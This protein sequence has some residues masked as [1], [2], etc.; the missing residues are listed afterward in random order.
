MDA[1]L[2]GAAI[3]IFL[4]LVFRLTGKRALAQITTFDFVLLLI[5][6]E[7]TQQALVG[8]DY[9]LTGAALLIMTL[10]VLDLALSLVKQRS[11]WFQRLTEGAP[12]VILENGKPLKERMSKLRIDEGDIL[13]AA[14]E[15]QGLERLEQIKYAV[16]ERS[17][18]ITVIPQPEAK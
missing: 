12:L 3:Y 13:Q 14:R 5:I 6:S 2:R 15:S 10:V 16:L 4:L 8:K 1:I 17:G 11:H 18:G 9:S 7:T